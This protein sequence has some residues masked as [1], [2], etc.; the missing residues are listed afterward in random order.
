MMTFVGSWDLVR[1]VIA[2]TTVHDLRV[3]DQVFRI[4]PPLS[5]RIDLGAGLWAGPLDSDAVD[6][7]FEACRP[8][9]LN[10]NPTRQF[11]YHYCFVRDIRVP[12]R[13]SLTWDEDRRLQ[14]CVALSRLVHPTTIATHYSARLFYEGDALRQIVPGPTQG[15]GAYA[16]VNGHNWRNWLTAPEAQEVGQLLPLYAF[17]KMPARLRRAMR[18]F[19]YACHTYELD[20]RFTLVITGLEAL[21]NTHKYYVTSR[22]KKRVQLVAKDVGMTITEDESGDAY[23]YRSNFIHGQVLQGQNIGEKVKESYGPLETLLRLVV[24]KSIEDPTFSKRF[25]SESTIDAAYPV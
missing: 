20:L 14:D 11:G 21:V 13:S 25:E 10:F 1:D 24:K 9:G 5:E 4:D 12:S 2:Q 23:D 17:D 15:L 3:S 19:L 8:P 16:W 18:H 7:V 6:A 22:F